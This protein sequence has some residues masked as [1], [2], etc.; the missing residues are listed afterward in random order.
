MVFCKNQRSKLNV[1][2]QK[3]CFSTLWD[4]SEKISCYGESAVVPNLMTN[5]CGR[6]N[7]SGATSLRMIRNSTQDYRGIRKVKGSIGRFRTIQ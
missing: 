3:G 4:D 1:V 5:T 6:M 7:C 2:A